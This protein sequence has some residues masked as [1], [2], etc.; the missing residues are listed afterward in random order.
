MGTDTST[1]QVR[2]SSSP[3]VRFVRPVSNVCAQHVQVVAW[4]DD[5]LLEGEVAPEA[6]PV[7]PAGTLHDDFVYVEN[8]EEVPPDF[9]KYLPDY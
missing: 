3:D 5:C 8:A 9:H 2:F 4:T 6:E 1:K 7:N